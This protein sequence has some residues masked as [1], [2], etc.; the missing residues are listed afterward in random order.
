MV[1]RGTTGTSDPRE[2]A[3]QVTALRAQFDREV[4]EAQRRADQARLKK[5][6]DPA[7][8]ALVD[9]L[10][11]PAQ[12]VEAIEDMRRQMAFLIAALPALAGHGGEFDHD[13]AGR[14][15]RLPAGAGDVPTDT[16]DGV[17]QSVH[18]RAE[19]AALRAYMDVVTSEIRN[20]KSI[21]GSLEEAVSPAPAHSDEGV[22]GLR[23]LAERYAAAKDCPKQDRDARNYTVRRWVELHGDIPVARFERSHLST[24]SD[25]L[26]DLPTT[27]EKRV[28]DLSIRRAIAVGKA[29]G[30]PTGGDKNVQKRLDHMKSFTAYA[31]DQLGMIP[32][33]PF[34]K[35]GIIKSKVKH[36][37][38]AKKKTKP[39]SPAQIRTILPH[40]AGRFEQDTLDR[41]APIISAYTGARREEIGQLHV[42]NIS[43]WRNGL[44]IT[45]TDE[46]EMQ[47]VKNRHSFRTIPVPPV[48][49]DAGFGD[50]VARRRQAG[51][52]MLFMEGHT[53]NRSKQI[54]LREV[55]TNKRGRYTETYGTRFARYVREPLK[56]IEPGLT[57]HSMRHS[58]TDAARRA[59]ISAEIRRL[60]AG[61]LD[62][63]DAVES[64]YGGA[65][66]LAEKMEAMIAVTPYLTKD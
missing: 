55:C 10:G 25:A 58:W 33:D 30:L 17:A 66:L 51:G 54:L 19:E 28:Q 3:R 64:L 61:R 39:Y 23:E 50:F 15:I 8:A 48:L 13:R 52:I 1:K 20:L 56:L 14:R 12:V 40:C 47:K 21:A 59:G 36:S 5:L 53:R 2:A 24:F 29:E 41:W 34:V 22:M 62:G 37:A 63:E 11:G 9:A 65:D 26:R 49:L 32:A 16:P 42:A 60:I 4:K 27:R 44:T 7:D 31:V 38:K 46:A 6:L 35:F 43:D 57:F 45:I 18:D